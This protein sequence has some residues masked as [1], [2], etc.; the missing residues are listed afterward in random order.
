MYVKVYLMKGF[1]LLLVL[2]MIFSFLPSGMFAKDDPDSTIENES[3]TKDKSDEDA[4]ELDNAIEPENTVVSEVA[5]EPEDIN[6][7]DDIN[8]PEDAD[9]PELS[10]IFSS[11]VEAGGQT[12]G[13]SGGISYP[14]A[15]NLL[16]TKDTTPNN[17]PD[18]PGALLLTKKAAPTDRSDQP[19]NIFEWEITLTLRGLD[20]ITT[21]DIVLLFDASPSMNTSGKL[22]NAKLAANEFVDELLYTGNNGKTR[23]ALVTFTDVANVRSGFTTNKSSLNTAINAISTSGNTNMQAGFIAAQNLL[24]SSTAGNKYIVLLGDGEPTR[25]MLATGVT[26]VVYDHDASNNHSFNINLNNINT[27]DFAIDFSDSSY[28]STGSNVNYNTNN[29]YLVYCGQ[30][31]G[32]HS[33]SAIFPPDHGIPSVYQA[34]LAKAQGIEIYSVAVLA[35]TNGNA[36]LGN[37]SSGQGSGYYYEINNAGDVSNLSAIF[38]NIAGK[39]K[40]AAAQSVVTDPLGDYFTLVTRGASGEPGTSSDI[41]VPDG[42][43]V[44]Y[45]ADNRTIIWNVGVIKEADGLYTMKYLVRID[46]TSG[47]TFPDIMY[48]TNLEDTIVDFINVY[49][50]PERLWFPIPKVAYPQVGSITVYRYLLDDQGRPF[51]PQRLPATDI[52]LVEIYDTVELT[53][54][55]LYNDTEHP[56][57]TSIPYD[58]YTV[59]EG[60]LGDPITV[61]GD[62]YI[63]VQGDDINLG[64]TLPKSVTV[65]VHN[66]NVG[67]YCAYVKAIPYTVQYYYDGEIDDALTENL[68]AKAVDPHITSVPLDGKEKIGY[69]MADPFTNPALPVNITAANNVIKVYFVKD[70]SQTKEVSYYVNYYLDGELAETITVTESIWV[71]DDIIKVRPVNTDDD[72]Y[73]GYKFDR[74]DPAEIPEYAEDGYEID[75]YYVSDDVKT[76]KVGY[77]VEYYLDGVLKE[78]ARVS[79]N[80]R[81]NEPSIINIKNVDTRTDKYTGYKF[82][83]TD[84]AELPETVD[85][86]YVIKVYYVKDENQTRDV[87]YKVKYTRDGAEVTADSYTV[88][89]K[90][91]INDPDGV[92]VPVAP[93]SAAND[94]YSGYQLKVNPFVAPATAKNGDVIT[95]EYVSISTPPNGNGKVSQGGTG[96]TGVPAVVEETKQIVDDEIPE[97]PAIFIK[98]HVAYIIGYP[99][100][101]VRPE[102]N[103]TRAE[104]VTAFYRLL[105]DEM[106]ESHWSLKNNYPDVPQ[107]GWYIAPVSVMTNIGIIQGD[108]EGRFMPDKFITRAELAAVA[109]RFARLMKLNGHDLTAGFNDIVGHWAEEDIVYVA[110]VGWYVG[111]KDGSFKPDQYITRAEFMAI[112]NRMLKRVPESINDIIKY[113]MKKWVDNSDTEAW[114]YLIVQEATNTHTAEFKEGKTVP[115]VLFEYERWLEMMKNPDWLALEEIWKIRNA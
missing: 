56:E 108:H 44:E 30:N 53:R 58:T 41:I 65:N 80:V 43:A 111:Y 13:E 106:R 38:T 35:G 39:I 51:T 87:V 73:E 46:A 42:T 15:I 101:D 26:G 71:N 4:N 62:V 104:V 96:K 57:Y 90:V 25:S 98:D 32:S 82:S 64:D 54:G 49:D 5:I 61:N 8:E 66:S 74:T 40:Y 59:D 67:I 77:T 29:G 23:I 68:Y 9:E 31:D 48:P 50:E 70:P 12:G 28:A 19:N 76:K 2:A 17:E 63:Y 16:E 93:I 60:M 114:Y 45:D 78:T 75:V 3:Y 102:N 33:Y 83:Y 14:A 91:W 113:K 18:I 34:K 24:S 89:V 55:V 109:A 105:T 112:V 6:A 110:S 52:N 1:A 79:E 21:S 115:G 103:I 92:A 10:G 22:A 84:P 36:V 7:P 11:G 47:A 95:V 100:G 86:G 85:D 72:R 88:T 107:D 81:I 20:L 94:R 69:K 27:T 97:A 99:E 37:T